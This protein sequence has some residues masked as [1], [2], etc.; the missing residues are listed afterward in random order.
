MNRHSAA[1]TTA[2]IVL[3]LPGL[4]RAGAADE[5]RELFGRYEKEAAVAKDPNAAA[6]LAA[7][8]LNASTYV[9]GNDPLKVLLLDKAYEYGIK[10][11]AGY[12]V[13]AD[14]LEMLVE[15]AP[16]R[17]VQA[18]LKLIEITR[19]RYYRAVGPR[20][21]AIGQALVDALVSL[22]DEAAKTA[23]PGEALD[24][25]RLALWVSAD[26]PPKRTAEIVSK[27]TTLAAKQEGEDKAAALKAP[28]GNRQELAAWTYQALFGQFEKDAAG[29]AD[30]NAS[31]ELASRLVGTSMS[32]RGQPWIQGLLCQKAYE[33]GLKTPAGQPVASAAM[34]LLIDAAPEYDASAN[35]KLLAV[36][37]M[38]YARESGDRRKEAGQDVVDA[39]LDRGDESVKARRFT[40]ALGC[41]KEALALAPQVES[42]RADETA[43]TIKGLAPALKAEKRV[44]SLRAVLA[45]DAN[46]QAVRT[47]LILAY[48]GA[49]DAPAEAA[50]LL[51]PE[52][53]EQL[54]ANV[55]LAA[56]P[57]EELD[58]T[59]CLSLARWH[60]AI[61][62][63]APAPDKGA[64]LD[65]AVACCEQ[66]LRR[67]PAR[68]AG[69]L[70][71]ALLM[72]KIDKAIAEAGHTPKYV[73]LAMEDGVKMKMVLIQ[74]GSFLMGSPDSEGRPAFESP[75]HRVTI[76][77]PFYIGVYEVTQEQFEQLIAVS[78]SRFKGSCNPAD[79]VDFDLAAA[80]CKTLSARTGKAITLPTEAQWEY[81]C[82]AGA[83]TAYFFGSNPEKLGEYAWFSGN[84]DGRTHAVGLKKPNPAG[85]YD[86]YGNALEWCSDAW[87]I[88]YDKSWRT[89]PTGIAFRGS[90]PHVTRGEFW[91]SGGESCR[92][93]CRHGK[94]RFV[95]DEDAGQCG[96]RVVMSVEDGK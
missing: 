6:H 77:R 80:F 82:R 4:A 31:V 62:A 54:R 19:L 86:V 61:A 13:A 72:E 7:R 52:L 33:L 39:I 55:Q 70:R 74:P 47:E 53:D 68:D 26:G 23:R 10:A 16:D 42:D 14:A 9:D 29:S 49:F 3:C 81:A 41:Y 95:P 12:D 51:T 71:Y 32:M 90:T 58:E 89:D 22:A 45:R 67:H 66:Y 25:Y 59:S 46:N 57:V 28:A 1:L 75:R 63:V 84:S 37:R 34:K 78:P 73:A 21:K 64:I 96:L 36:S 17:Q 56:R 83:K 43:R 69:L 5:Y 50:S 8:L 92:S 94:W 87:S 15:V 91:K 27:I 38:I 35:D 44:A 60:L 11:P 93:A 88:A 2:W 65:K 24:L 76:T 48:L 20:R 30:P 79:Q 40:E 18:R 85:L